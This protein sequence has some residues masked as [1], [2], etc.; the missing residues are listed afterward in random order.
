MGL[1]KLEQ[2]RHGMNL[3]MRFYNK[4]A[5]DLLDSARYGVLIDRIG[6]EPDTLDLAD[7][8]CKGYLV[9]VALREDEGK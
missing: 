5:A 2:A 3:L 8:W 9:G 1:A 7:D 6:D 4:V